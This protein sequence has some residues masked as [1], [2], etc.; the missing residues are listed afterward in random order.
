M[1]LAG[2]AREGRFNVYSQSGRLIRH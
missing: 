2:F 1:T